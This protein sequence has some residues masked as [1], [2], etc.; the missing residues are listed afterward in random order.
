ML[1]E[2]LWPDSW[3]VTSANG[4]RVP[5]YKR[6]VVRLQRALYGH[7]DAGTYWEMHCDDCLRR[8]GF[9]PVDNWPSCYYHSRLGLFLSVYV[10]DFK[11]AGPEA[12]MQEG[13]ALIMKF[14]QM[15]DPSPAAL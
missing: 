11:M 6:P 13:W 8:V 2:E 3:W 1:P 4:T 9:E 15:E 12:S 14:I 10:D 7:P 5:K